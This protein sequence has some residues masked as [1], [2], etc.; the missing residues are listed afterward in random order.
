MPTLQISLFRI[1]A[2]RRGSRGFTLL[3]VMVVLLIGSI[4][5]SMAVKGFG[6]TSSNLAT[7]QARTVYNGMVARARAQA[8]ESGFLTLVV[9]NIPGDSVW[10]FANG[11]VVENV[12]FSEEM[13]VDIRASS[14]TVR[15]CMSPRGY[16]NLDCNSFTSVMKMSFVQGAEEESIEILPLGQI[17]W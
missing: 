11:Q 13:G 14:P 12:R 6:A 8:I 10:I 4:L 3:E 5:M 1:E 9:A 15:L 7:R 2:M 17:R 16:A